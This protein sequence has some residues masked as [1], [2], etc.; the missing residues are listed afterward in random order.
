MGGRQT[1]VRAN[2]KSGE[3]MASSTTTYSLLLS[4][5][6]LVQL[7]ELA[8]NRIE[9]VFDQTEKEA[10]HRRNE[11][12]RV[13]TLIAV[14]RFSGLV[15]AFLVAC[16]GIGAAVYLAVQGKEITASIIGG[17]TVVGLVAAF[18]SAGKQ[19]KS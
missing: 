1:Q 2:S 8:P 18:V 13:N 17:T 5:Q 10:D 11:N 3:L 6:Q 15:F 9:W 12:R 4:I 7:K 16:L 19:K 14:E